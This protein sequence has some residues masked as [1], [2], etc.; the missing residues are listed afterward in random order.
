MSLTN[1]DSENRYRDYLSLAVLCA[2]QIKD[3][4]LSQETLS[5]VREAENSPELARGA[6]QVGVWWSGKSL[7][8]KMEKPNHL[9]LINLKKTLY[10]D[11]KIALN[12]FNR[13]SSLAFYTLVELNLYDCPIP[14]DVQ[15]FLPNIK[16]L[17]LSNCSL[18]IISKNI[19]KLTTLTDLSLMEGSISTIPNEIDQLSNLT[20]LSLTGNQ[21]EDVPNNISNLSNLQVIRLAKNKF[22]SIPLPIMHLTGLKTLL[23]SSNEISNLPQ[24]IALLTNLDVLHIN[25]NKIKSIQP[26]L[27]LNLTILKAGSNPI[28]W[29]IKLLNRMTQ[30]YSQIIGIENEVF[31]LRE[32]LGFQIPQFDFNDILKRMEVLVQRIEAE[33]FKNSEELSGH[34]RLL[35]KNLSYFE[36]YSSL[37][38]LRYEEIQELKSKKFEV[39]AR[40][41]FKNIKNPEDVLFFLQGI[42]YLF[43]L[44]STIFRNIDALE[45]YSFLN[46]IFN[47]A[48]SN[49]KIQIKLVAFGLTFLGGFERSHALLDPKNL[50][51]EIHPLLNMKI[52]IEPYLFMS[53]VRIIESTSLSNNRSFDKTKKFIDQVIKRDPKRLEIFTIQYALKKFNIATGAKCIRQYTYKENWANAILCVEKQ[54]FALNLRELSKQSLNIDCWYYEDCLDR[55]MSEY[56]K[57]PDSYKSNSIFNFLYRQCFL[58]TCFVA[59]RLQSSFFLKFFCDSLKNPSHHKKCLEAIAVLLRANP[60]LSISNEWISEDFIKNEISTYV[61]QTPLEGEKLAWSG[62]LM[63][64]E[65]P[66]FGKEFLNSSVLP[67]V[68]NRNEITVQS[69]KSFWNSIYGIEDVII[70]P[71][72]NRLCLQ[73]HQFYKSIIVENEKRLKEV[74]EKFK[75][76][77]KNELQEVESGRRVMLDLTDRIYNDRMYGLNRRSERIN[78]IFTQMKI[79]EDNQFLVQSQAIIVNSFSPILLLKNELGNVFDE[80]ITYNTKALKKLNHLK[81]SEEVDEEMQEKDK[82]TQDLIERCGDLFKLFSGEIFKAEGNVINEIYQSATK[83]YNSNAELEYQKWSVE[84]AAKRE[85]LMKIISSK[86]QLTSPQMQPD[87]IRDIAE[88]SFNSANLE[89]YDIKKNTAAANEKLKQQIL[90]FSNQNFPVEKN[91]NLQIEESRTVQALKLKN[92]KYKE[93]KKQLL[94]EVKQ[95][96][97]EKSLLE[98]QVEDQPVPKVV[99]QPT[100]PIDI[101]DKFKQIATSIQEEIQLF[102]DY[103]SNFYLKS[104]HEDWRKG[105]ED[106]H[107]N[108]EKIR[109]MI[110]PSKRNW[111][112]QELVDLLEYVGFHKPRGQA[113]THQGLMQ[114][115]FKIPT[116]VSF[117]T[118]KEVSLKLMNRYFELIYQTL[119]SWRMEINNPN[120]S[121]LPIQKVD[122]SS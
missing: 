64:L 55:F 94:I 46:P 20:S 113:G 101:E 19:L 108:L 35:I 99:Q 29:N 82:Y 34:C 52:M 88:G 49:T 63:L 109:Q 31:N 104:W 21:I 100:V 98:K 14:D 11:K 27:M 30:N 39:V 81:S 32:N 40:Y 122:V 44:D 26:L 75:N 95:L 51:G 8:Q 59:N 121:K 78:S 83:F 45:V 106:L 70:S 43:F 72:I 103:P 84:D 110:K 102:Q 114:P 47:G 74:F 87:F 76:T 79:G 2:N 80:R 18:S 53:L 69:F 112:R 90:D 60:K 33:N 119:S 42:E 3:P 115:F 67:L 92:K 86:S 65:I 24:E 61:Q 10:N 62:A 48:L 36:C 41:I 117:N 12:G 116:S 16:I 7:D 50:R 5:K 111:P 68:K 54:N 66:L 37:L 4:L 118:Q 85:D 56:A 96:K 91:I 1:V 73:F 23:F 57:D 105:W 15:I 58:N 38:A 89:F 13:I 107:K 6:V 93:E 71:I 28:R 25:S 17:T 22:R 9:T 120:L 97:F 77:I